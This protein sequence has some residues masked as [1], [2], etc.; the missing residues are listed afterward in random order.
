MANTIIPDGECY[1]VVKTSQQWSETATAY[2]VIPKGV[3]CVEM[4]SPKKFLLKI[5]DGKQQYAKLPYIGGDADLTNYYTKSETDTIIAEAIA[6]LGHVMRLRGIVNS[7]RDLPKHGNKVGDVYIVDDITEQSQELHLV[8]E[9][10][11]IPEE[12][13]Y[14]FDGFGYHDMD[15][16]VKREEFEDTVQSLRD[17]DEELRQMI[18]GSGHVHNNKDILD[19]ITAPYTVEDQQMLYTIS[20]HAVLDWDKLRLYC[21]EVPID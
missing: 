12:K 19:R 13:W 2:R 15:D 18:I 16:Y 11:W 5:G 8:H 7:V 4:V 9:V 10:V 6:A 21:D 3:V 17:T 1:H 20:E 14:E